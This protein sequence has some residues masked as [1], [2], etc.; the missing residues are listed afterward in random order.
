[1]LYNILTRRVRTQRSR[2]TRYI[3]DGKYISVLSLSA[4][5]TLQDRSEKRHAASEITFD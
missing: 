1:M 5:G 3:G 2:H 4:I